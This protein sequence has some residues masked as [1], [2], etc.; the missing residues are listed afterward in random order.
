MSNSEPSAIELQSIPCMCGLYKFRFVSQGPLAGAAGAVTP[1]E[2]ASQIAPNKARHFPLK[3]TK[4][5]P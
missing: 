4:K 5:G 2:R 1:R 3:I